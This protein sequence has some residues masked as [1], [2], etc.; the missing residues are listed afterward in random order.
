MNT[1]IRTQD[2]VHCTL[3]PWLL[4]ICLV[5]LCFILGVRTQA[6]TCIS[7]VLVT[8]LHTQSNVLAIDGSIFV[9]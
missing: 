4:F 7:K 2:L 5:L 3:R 1:N 6:F 9:A 8:E